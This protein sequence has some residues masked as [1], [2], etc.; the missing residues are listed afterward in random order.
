VATVAQ[1]QYRTGDGPVMQFGL[2]AGAGTLRLPRR[3]LC[4]RNKTTASIGIPNHQLHWRSPV[5]NGWRHSA[6]PICRR[7][8]K[9]PLPMTGSHL[10]ITLSP[11]L[12]DRMA[13]CGECVS[14]PGS[15]ARVPRYVGPRTG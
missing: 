7:S 4:I 14:V 2:Q 3:R 5:T 8:G 12:I 11:F 15:S 6:L 9:L 13:R 10:P 1:A